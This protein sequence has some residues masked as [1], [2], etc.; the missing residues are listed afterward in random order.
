MLLGLPHPGAP[1]GARP[2]PADIY[3][4][5]KR[6]AWNWVNTRRRENFHK[7]PHISRLKLASNGRLKGGSSQLLAL[8]LHF[9]EFC[10]RDAPFSALHWA[11]F[12]LF[13]CK[14]MFSSR[15]GGA[16]GFAEKSTEFMAA[17]QAALLTSHSLRS[18]APTFS[19]Y[20]FVMHALRKRRSIGPLTGTGNR[21]LGI[22]GAWTGSL[23]PLSHPVQLPATSTPL[24]GMRQISTQQTVQ[25]ER[26]RG[27]EKAVQLLWQLS[28]SF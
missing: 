22:Q 25:R 15:R 10:W 9:L 20:W 21:V 26:E 23:P 17:F 16:G 11:S 19:L 28:P 4:C 24:A 18:N 5:Q 3:G 27:P 2:I 12:I 13:A 8:H 14:Q 6:S 7:L 1:A